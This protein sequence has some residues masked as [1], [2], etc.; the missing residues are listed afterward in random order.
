[1]FVMHQERCHDDHDFTRAFV[2]WRSSDLAKSGEASGI[3]MDKN[4][5]SGSHPE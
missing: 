2:N 1:M 5:A 4:H 3:R